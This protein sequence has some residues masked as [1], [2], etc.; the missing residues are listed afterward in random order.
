[1]KVWGGEKQHRAGRACTWREEVV[2][3]KEWKYGSRR[4]IIGQVEEAEHGERHYRIGRVS[5][6][7]EEVVQ[8]TGE[9]PLQGRE[10]HYRVGR[11]ITGRTGQ[12]EVV[13]VEEW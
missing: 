10:R 9:E 1:M 11:D 13:Q 7:Q 2:H 5:T 4:A 3:A 6:G 8:V 12:A